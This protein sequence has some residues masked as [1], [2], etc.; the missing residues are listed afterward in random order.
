MEGHL[1]VWPGGS[2]GAHLMRANFEQVREE[3]LQRGLTTKQEIEQ[4]LAL[5][6]DPA[7]AVSSPVMFSAWGRRSTR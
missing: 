3:A 1:A 7:F 5:L 4:V 6:D 2:A